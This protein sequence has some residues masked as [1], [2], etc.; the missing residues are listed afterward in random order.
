M[1]PAIDTPE[2][3]FTVHRRTLLKVASRYFRSQD[4]AEDCVQDALLRIVRFW[5][6][7]NEASP[8]TWACA[9]VKN[10]AL[11][12]HRKRN[13]RGGRHPHFALGELHEDPGGVHPEASLVAKLMI[14]RAMRSISKPL[15][16]ATE[17][18]M[19]GNRHAGNKVQQFRARKA[20]RRVMAA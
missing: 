14:E 4:D 9:V 10:A 1:T 7:C 5:G 8:L 2:Q 16:T 12:K 15:R 13:S 3:L 20:M 17:E 11:D 19:D 18:W 6:A